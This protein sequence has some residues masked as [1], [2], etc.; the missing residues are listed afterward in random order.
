LPN[1]VFCDKIKTENPHFLGAY[2][3]DLSSI[4]VKGPIFIERRTSMQDSMIIELY[5]QRDEKAIAATQD[6]YGAY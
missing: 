5:N 1:N 2:S 4:W 6:K 3:R